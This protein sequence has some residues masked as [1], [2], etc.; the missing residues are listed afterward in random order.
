[1]SKLN[2]VDQKFGKVCKK[3]GKRHQVFATPGHNLPKTQKENCEGDR[4]ARNR[5]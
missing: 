2:W 1:M 3:C 5:P 4:V